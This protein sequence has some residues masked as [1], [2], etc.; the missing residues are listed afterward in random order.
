MR[1][2]I[3]TSVVLAVIFVLAL[4]VRNATVAEDPVAKPDIQLDQARKTVRMLDDIYKGA[5]V[6]ITKNYVNDTDTIPAGTAFKQLFVA[7]EAKGW[8]R[9]RLLDCTGEPY[10]DENVAEDKFEKEALR[11]LVG[12]KAWVEVVEK[13][14][15][16]RHLR[17][18]T[19]I[20]V[21]MDKC[22]MCH[23][24]YADLPAGKAIGALT[25]VV[26]IDGPLK[27]KGAPK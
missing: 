6:A 14:E 17:V 4:L 8:A 5:V 3:R 27:T 10:N 1:V 2:L 9:T 21:V 25:Y 12:G 19:A 24:N 7:A 15:G 11:A 20:P 13:I 26:P 22:V 18:A 16:V 23:D